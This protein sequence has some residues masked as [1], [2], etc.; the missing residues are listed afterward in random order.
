MITYTEASGGSGGY[1][2]I[3]EEG[4]SLPQRT[5]MDFVGAGVT[6]TDNGSKTVVTV[7]I[8]PAYATIQEEGTPLTQQS[9]IDF[10]GAGVTASNGSGKTVVTVPIQ[11]AYATIQDEGSALAQQPIIDFV[12]AGVTATN[13]SGKTIVTINGSAV[14]VISL[15]NSAML[16]LISG[17]T[18]IVG[19]FYIITDA[20]YSN[21]GGVLVQGVTTSSITR[22]GTGLFF[23]ADYQGVGNYSTISPSYGTNLGIWGNLTSPP[24]VSAGDVVVWNNRNYVNLTG[25][26]G[27]D[28]N[29]DTINWSLLVYSATKGYIFETDFVLYDVDTNNIVF[30]ADK[31]NNEVDLYN[32]T[33]DLYNTLN[34]FQWGRDKAT[35]NKI[36]GK[37]NCV[38]TNSNATITGNFLENGT[39]IDTTIVT[40]AG[41]FQYNTITAQAIVVSARTS[42]NFRNNVISGVASSVTFAYLE[43]TS[44]FTNNQ[45]LEGSVFAA[46]CTTNTCQISNNTLIGASNITLTFLGTSVDSMTLSNNYLSNGGILTFGGA[47]PTVSSTITGCQ[48]SDGITVDLGNIANVTY[49]N[50][51]VYKGYS[52]WEAPSPLEL[53]NPA[54]YNSGTSTLT[55][56]T[57]LAYVGIFVLGQSSGSVISSIVNAPTNHNFTLR[58]SSSSLPYNFRLVPIGISTSSA[59]NIIESG[60]INGGALQTYTARVNGCD[61]A[62]LGKFGNLVGLQIQNIWV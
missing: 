25:A 11:P 34:D 10:Q 35:Y 46:Q 5:T 26:W 31:R 23:N 13:G 22:S 27:T 58:P 1:T 18:V 49:T 33:A 20:N 6:A 45:I 17:S 24:P 28:P 3:Q 47:L 44:N 59:N 29:G 55:L 50:K 21:A 52:N 12:G 53:T 4:S 37:S 40:E 54:I 15:L 32:N 8:Q 7:P 42:G 30:R 36:K 57:S 19:Q 2:T 43:V 48:V 39:Y 14:S 41:N 38:I 62:I 60:V 9:V 56:P 61:E 16:L 51:K